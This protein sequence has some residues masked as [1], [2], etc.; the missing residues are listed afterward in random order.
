MFEGKMY[1]RSV[2]LLV[3]LSLFSMGSAADE[4]SQGLGGSVVATQPLP[5]AFSV[6]GSANP[7]LNPSADRVVTFHL[8]LFSGRVK[9]VQGLQLGAISNHVTSDFIGYDATGIY[10]RVDGNFAGFQAGALASRVDGIFIG[11]QNGGIY[12]KVGSDF[13]GF[14]VSGVVN[15]VIG[16]F[17]GF[18]VS[19]IHN[20]SHRVKFAQIAGISNQATDVE[21][22]QIAGIVNNAKH[23]KGVQIGLINRSEKLDGIAIGLVNLSKSGSIHLVSWGSLNEDYQ[24]GVKFAPNDYWYTTLTMGQQALPSGQNRLS[25]F[26]SHMGFHVPL[27]AKFYAEIDLGSGNTIPDKF[28]SWESGESQHILETR[29]GIGVQITPRFSVVAGFS[30]KRTF[31]DLDTWNG[32]TQEIKPFFGIQ[33]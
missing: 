2:L 3:T 14:Q 15:E 21:G 1:K 26:E 5:F 29:L 22:V 11:M 23:V 18:Q 33:I 31:D 10:S 9:G 7:A 16:D 19:G 12:N 27:A 24:I 17:T 28:W 4:P 25:S 30:D 6:F 32:S 13:F 20:T 8:S